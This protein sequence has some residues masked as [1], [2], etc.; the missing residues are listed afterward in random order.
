MTVSIDQLREA[1]E[2]SR[3]IFIAF[4]D[5]H[6]QDI[7]LLLS[8]GQPMSVR[9]LAD[10]LQIS[11]PAVSHHLKILKQAGLLSERSEG[12]KTYYYP[13]LRGA[14]KKV[15]H[16]IDASAETIHKKEEQ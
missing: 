14:I 2:D 5:R 9:E 11:R 6:R 3:D 15:K 16:L 7:I 8:G 12:V 10:E 4:G 1:F 13:Q